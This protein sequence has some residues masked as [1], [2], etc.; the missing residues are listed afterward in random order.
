MSARFKRYAGIEYSVAEV[1]FRVFFIR[2][3]K[4]YATRQEQFPRTPFRGIWSEGSASSLPTT[5]EATPLVVHENQRHII[6]GEW[7][8]DHRLRV[9]WDTILNGLFTIFSGLHLTIGLS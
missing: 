3:S 6:N 7:D 5:R 4:Q 8:A 1:M 9:N 2:I